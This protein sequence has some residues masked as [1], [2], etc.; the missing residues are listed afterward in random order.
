MFTHY[1]RQLR[2]GCSTSDQQLGRRPFLPSTRRPAPVSNRKFQSHGT[3]PMHLP[4]R[5]KEL[6]M[7]L[8]SRHAGIATFSG[9]FNTSGVSHTRVI[10]SLVATTAR[11][12]RSYSTTMRFT[13]PWIAITT[14]K[15]RAVCFRGVLQVLP[16]LLSNILPLFQLN[17]TSCFRMSPQ[18]G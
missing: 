9:S 1:G 8:V 17:V 16:C 2:Q 10:A 6:F 11:E 12:R 5:G 13:H 4:Q 15:A 18:N 7:S 3:M 14:L